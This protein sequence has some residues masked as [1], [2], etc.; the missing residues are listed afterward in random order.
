MPCFTRRA[1]DAQV[2]LRI[3]PFTEGEA[4]WRDHKPTITITADDCVTV[5]PPDGSRSG[6]RAGSYRFSKVHG[7][8]TRQ[9]RFYDSVMKPMVDKAMSKGQNGLMF[10]YGTRAL[11]LRFWSWVQSHRTAPG[12]SVRCAALRS[13]HTTCVR[14]CV[15]RYD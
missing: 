10:A 7:P 1:C 6:E 15:R 4:H 11:R 9:D 13:L 8:E 2:H 3:R 5:D 12:G 14:V